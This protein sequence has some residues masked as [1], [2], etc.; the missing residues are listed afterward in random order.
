[1]RIQKIIQKIGKNINQ[2]TFYFPQEGP[3]RASENIKKERNVNGLDYFF[4]S[5]FLMEVMGGKITIN[6]KELHQNTKSRNTR[7]AE[8]R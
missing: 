7:T 3:D 4:F 8:K 1:L 2:I 6:I 5:I